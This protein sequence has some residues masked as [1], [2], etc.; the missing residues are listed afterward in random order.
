LRDVV[1]LIDSQTRLTDFK[2]VF[3]GKE[4]VNPIIWTGTPTELYYFIKYIHNIQK[5]VEDAKKQ[6][7]K[8]TCHCFIGENN[9]CFDKSKLK[10]LKDP[11]PQSI[12]KIEKAA[13][14]LTV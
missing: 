11:N 1:R 10:S 8:I 4:V 2:K 14:N 9:V 12:A 3:S 5:S 7:W 6:Q 13:N